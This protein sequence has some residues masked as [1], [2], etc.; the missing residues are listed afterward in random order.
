MSCRVLLCKCVLAGMRLFVCLIAIALR[1]LSD[2]VIALRLLLSYFFFLAAVVA[3]GCPFL[4]LFLVFWQT[5]PFAP[6][7]LRYPL[8]RFLEC[9]LLIC[10][11]CLLS[12]QLK[13]KFGVRDFLVSTNKHTRAHTHILQRESCKHTVI[14]PHPSHSL[15]MLFA[16]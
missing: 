16:G 7:P 2:F 3:L 9:C 6:P 12:R 11:S 14:W 15:H 13:I 5:F 10:C 1:P 8:F 4:I